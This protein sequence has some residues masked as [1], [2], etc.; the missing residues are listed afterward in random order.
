MMDTFIEDFI[1][2]NII[3][4]AEFDKQEGG[5]KKRFLKKFKY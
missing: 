1:Q 5:K 4:L 2:N 3:K